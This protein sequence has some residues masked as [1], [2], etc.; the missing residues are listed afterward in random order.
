MR[1]SSTLRCSASRLYR[2]VDLLHR[3]GAG[4]LFTKVPATK[5][6]RR[7]IATMAAAKKV[8]VPIGTGTEEMEA[9]ITIDVLRRAG[10]DGE[11]VCIMPAIGCQG[12]TPTGPV[13][14]L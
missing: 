8:L 14:T 7:S 13:C 9:V 2:G 11:N 4:A 10:A 5:V 3:T 6:A 1:G 12:E